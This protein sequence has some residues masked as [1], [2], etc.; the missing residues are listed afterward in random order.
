MKHPVPY[1]CSLCAKPAS[2][3]IDHVLAMLKLCQVCFDARYAKGLA[4]QRAAS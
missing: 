3:P 4:A 1:A 2:A